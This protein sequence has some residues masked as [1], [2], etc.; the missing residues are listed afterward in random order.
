MC[1][2]SLSLLPFCSQLSFLFFMQLYPCMRN[3]VRGQRPNF[4]DRLSRLIRFVSSMVIVFVFGCSC[5]IM[6]IYLFC[7]CCN[8]FRLFVCC[9][10]LVIVGFLRL[11]HSVWNNH[12]GTHLHTHWRNSEFSWQC[13]L[14][15]CVTRKMAF[16]LS[17][18][19]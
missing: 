2:F 4:S 1:V 14:G 8:E 10:V 13:V 15:F 3:N 18:N 16:S 11:A 9:A 17:F 19:C 12:M 6:F 7:C 5:S